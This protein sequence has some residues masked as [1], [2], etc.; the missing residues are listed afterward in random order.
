[1]LPVQSKM[2]RTALGWGIR[3]AA[4][5]ARC[6]TETVM[7]LEH[8]ARLRPAT[9]A[10]IRAGYERAGIEF[11]GGKRPGVRIEFIGGKKP[12]VRVRGR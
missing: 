8:G 3:D 4:K 7:R 12:G 9:I 2:A 1:M 5:A 6:S 11:V 10:R